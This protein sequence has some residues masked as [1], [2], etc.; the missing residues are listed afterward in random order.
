[1]ESTEPNSIIHNLRSYMYGEFVF[2]DTIP[3]LNRLR[4]ILKGY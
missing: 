3:F 2:S 1:M 4:W